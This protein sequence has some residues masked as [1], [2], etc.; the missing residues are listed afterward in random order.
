MADYDYTA[1]VA[2]ALID[3]WHVLMQSVNEKDAV[4]QQM[5]QYVSSIDHMRLGCLH[6]RQPP[7][8]KPFL[9]VDPVLSR[10]LLYLIKVALSFAPNAETSLPWLRNL[11]AF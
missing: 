1:N 10:Q 3:H 4:S 8:E 9:E 7:C 6:S 11:N 5:Q 2:N